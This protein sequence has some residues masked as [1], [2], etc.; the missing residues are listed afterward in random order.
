MSS[1]TSLGT[2]SC[3][4]CAKPKCRP[5]E[6]TCAACRKR[7]QRERERSAQLAAEEPRPLS[8]RPCKCGPG[9]VALKD[10][11]GVINCIA[12][13][14]SVSRTSDRIY[15]FDRYGWLMQTAADGCPHPMKRRRLAREWRTDGVP[16][17]MA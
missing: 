10:E 17:E 15:G 7:A 9:A 1:A 5:G 14:A 3:I 6:R 8:P 4:G 16:A 13:G 12:C 2:H 11:D